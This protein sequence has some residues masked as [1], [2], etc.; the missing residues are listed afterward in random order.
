MELATLNA[1]GLKLM[2]YGPLRKQR[3]LVPQRWKVNVAHKI[4]RE[5]PVLSKA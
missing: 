5:L 3:K 2:R 1:D 4:P